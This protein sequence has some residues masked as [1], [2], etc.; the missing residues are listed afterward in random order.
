MLD[1]TAVYPLAR[2][3]NGVAANCRAWP[4]CEYERYVGSILV[5]DNDHLVRV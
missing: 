4:A 2:G 5:L 3:L 1:C